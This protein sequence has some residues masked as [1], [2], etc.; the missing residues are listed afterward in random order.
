[1]IQ[2]IDAILK[3]VDHASNPY[4]VSL[5][6]GT[7]D[8][9]DFV[10]TQIQFFFAVDFFS[11]P[12]AAVAAKIPN[13]RQ[14]VEVLRNVWEEHGEGE[15]VQTHSE[16]FMT[17]LSRLDG[18]K[19]SEIEARVLWPEVR[20]FNT[21]LAGA[22]VLD[23][24]PVSVSMMGM[25]ERMFSDISAWIGTS[26]VDQGWITPDQMIHYNLHQD[27]DIR[28]SDDFFEVVLSQWNKNQGNDR[29]A[30]E[31]GLRLGATVFNGMYE[32]LYRNRKRR[33]MQRENES[34]ESSK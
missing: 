30:I 4:F 25:V 6:D 10:E 27:L 8:K 3:E 18:V 20:V 26:V 13:A 24:Y 7:F 11:R 17:F 31:Q 14:R 32:G 15:E 9:E 21:T 12:M 1:M 33:W 5:R 23:D 22:A 29:Y 28:H 16:T 34:L 2:T 19:P